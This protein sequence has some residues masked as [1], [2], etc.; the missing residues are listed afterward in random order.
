MP[1]REFVIAAL[2]VL[3]LSAIAATPSPEAAWKA[4]IQDADKHYSAIPFAI[5][6]IQD[7]AYLRDGDIATLVGVKGNPATY[8]WAKGKAPHGVLTAGV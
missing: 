6:K 7:A 3:P 4:A 2:L 8:H 5:L 1:F